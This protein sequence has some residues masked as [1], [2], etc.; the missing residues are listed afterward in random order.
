MHNLT[1]YGIGVADRPRFHRGRWTPRQH[2]PDGGWLFAVTEVEVFGG[3]LALLL[4]FASYLSPHVKAYA[5]WR[6]GGAFGFKLNLSREARA[7]T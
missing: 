1:W 5:G 7:W 2:R 3:R 6:P 4:P